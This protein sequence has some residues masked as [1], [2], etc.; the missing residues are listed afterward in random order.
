M[1]RPV[2]AICQK[3][4]ASCYCPFVTPVDNH[5]ELIIWQHP[6]EVNHPKGSAGLLAACLSTVQLVIGEQFSL[7]EFNQHCGGSKIQRTLLSPVVP[8]K[9]D[10]AQKTARKK[11]LSEVVTPTTVQ[12]LII[13]DGSWR[14]AR[15]IYHLNPW[16]ADLP[17]M[18]LDTQHDSQYRIR[19]PEKDGQYSTLE[20]ACLGLAQLENNSKYAAIHQ[21]FADYI[22]H[23]AKFYPHLK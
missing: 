12:Q 22:N 8:L 11:S 19:K 4:P 17:Q 23:L 2:C 3:P 14:K 21:T 20:A 16:L 5:I 10:L 7:D 1:P 18:Q 6:N 9:L 15:K 13:I